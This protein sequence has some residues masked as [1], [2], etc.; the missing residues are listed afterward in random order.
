VGLKRDCLLALIPPQI[1]RFRLI[2]SKYRAVQA[3][4]LW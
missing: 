1:R 2:V 4:F 3:N